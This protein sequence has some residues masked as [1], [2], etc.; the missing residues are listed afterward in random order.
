MA[1]SSQKV[2]AN[3]R[4]RSPQIRLIG[5]AGEQFGIVTS[6]EGLQKAQDAGLD[7]VEVA[8]TT[9]PPVCRIMDLGKYLYMLE[10]KEK[11]SRK[12]QKVIDIKEVKMTTKIGDH[13]YQT[14]L[15]N[16]RGF[17]ERGDKVKLTVFFRGRE[18]VYVDKGRQ[19]VN[20]FV[21]DLSD[22]AMIER[23]VGLEGKA[24]QVYL[25][26]I[27]PVKKKEAVSASSQPTA[28]ATP[29]PQKTA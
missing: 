7:L 23:N 19:L 24:I 10:K 1:L 5:A 6:Q 11:E 20:R 29:P 22:I 28:P 14:K 13:D 15:R 2:R 21:L 16:A 27:A 18:I 25:T 12:K 17:I 8:G 3:E 9:T 4:I 26:K